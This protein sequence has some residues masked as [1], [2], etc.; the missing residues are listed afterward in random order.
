MSCHCVLYI[1]SCKIETI[2]E[3]L[4]E[5][6]YNLFQ[7]YHVRSC[8]TK[9]ENMVFEFEMPW[10]V[11]NE[12][13]LG[14]LNTELFQISFANLWFECSPMFGKIKYLKE[15]STICSDFKITHRAPSLGTNIEMKRWLLDHNHEDFLMVWKL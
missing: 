2:I 15:M 9:E 10:V 1:Q 8:N 5:E 12:F 6:K 14:F 3:S 13:I 11:N 4:L 7:N